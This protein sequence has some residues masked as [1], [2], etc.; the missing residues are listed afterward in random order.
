MIKW[1][2]SLF[3]LRV[4]YVCEWGEYDCRYDSIDHQMMRPIHSQMSVAPPWAKQ[5][6]IPIKGNC[7]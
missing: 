1:I 2:L 7:Q 4:I 3:G 6:W 5:K